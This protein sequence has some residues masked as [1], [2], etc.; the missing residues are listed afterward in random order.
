MNRLKPS[1][2]PALF[3]GALIFLFAAGNIHGASAAAPTRN[4]NSAAPYYGRLAELPVGAV[5]P[6]GWI[7]KWLERQAQGLTGHPENLA[8]PYDTC[9]YAGRIPP[10]GSN[11]KSWKEWWPYEQAG[12]FVDATTRLSWLIQDE[13]INERRDANLDYIL[14][15]SAGTNFGGSRWC[16]PNAV[17]G[18]ALMA[19]L[20]ATENPRVQA[21][22]QDWLLTSKDEI[23][24]GGRNG[25]NFEAAF[26][27]YSR[28]GDQR[29]LQLCR[30]IYE[31]YLTA[32]NSFCT[33]AKIMSAAPFHEHGV[34]AAET[35]KCLPLMYLYTG[36]TEAIDLARRAYQ[37]VVDNN[38]MADGGMVSAEFLDPVKFDSLHESCD[39][40]DWSW[41]M[42]YLAM[43]T[44]EGKWADLIE[45]TT[46]NA[47]PGA[48]TKDF[49][50][51][52]Y[53]SGANQLIAISDLN[54]VPHCRTRLTYRAAHDTEC[55]GGNIN[56]AM[57][58]YVT[59]MWMRSAENGVAALLYGPSEISTTI[60]NQK[61]VITEETEYPFGD[62]VAFRIKTATPVTFTL[63]LRIPAWC[64]NASLQ[65]NG[66]AYKEACGAGTFAAVHREFRDGDRIMLQL[67]MAVNI[68][69]A[70]GGGSGVVTRGPL[71]YSLPIAE[72][73]QEITT[74]PASIKALL[75]GNNIQGFPAVEFRPTGEWRYGL[76]ALQK[77][78]LKNIAVV[79]SP[80]T[81]NPFLQSPI[82]LEVQ[83]YQL[84]QWAPDWR[85]DSSKNPT[86]K[87]FIARSPSKLPGDKRQISERKTVTLK[88]VPYGS[89]HLRLTTLPYVS[90]EAKTAAVGSKTMQ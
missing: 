36:D 61:I 48:V 18:R 68:E 30:T 82:H 51:F 29:L 80:M 49:K 22:I 69:D 87:S 50:Q 72:Q 15:H 90:V 47:L 33:R 56:R 77:N 14:S 24:K 1:R 16:W 40:T 44:G 74:D 88:M 21:V 34:T 81:E 67:P 79:K 85:P 39:I 37:K 17:V 59:R 28:T 8:Y 41:S 71:V 65:L 6:R 4:D 5:Q 66:V 70:L 89:T 3:S 83:L 73:R 53:F 27:L 26:Y 35:L 60:N 31:N 43:A 76:D 78:H 32:T 10:P 12:Y 19:Q 45:R 86:A 13:S 54:G 55:C 58:N 20:S 64:T 25:A 46:F 75:H 62:V 7:Q 9:M 42:G 57:P 38:L 52:Q 23:T 84:P 63:N 11:W 2:L